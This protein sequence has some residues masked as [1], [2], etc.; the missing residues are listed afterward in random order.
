MNKKLI[1]G[2]ALGVVAV[3]APSM[4]W[5][6]KESD[7]EFNLAPLYLWAIAIDGDLYSGKNK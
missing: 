7:W 2:V 6:Q 1:L 4:A 5:T 3:M